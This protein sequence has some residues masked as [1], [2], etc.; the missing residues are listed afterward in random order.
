MLRNMKIRRK[1]IISFIIIGLFSIIVG[2]FGLAY[3]N[4]T[5][6]STVDIYEE[7]LIPSSYLF[8]VQ[9]NLI[10]IG[11]NYYLMLYEKD[12]AKAAKRVEEITAWTTADKELL[13]KFEAISITD[14]EKEIYTQLQ[15]DLTV[16][17][18]IRAEL[19]EFLLQN[20]FEEAVKLVPSFSEAREVVDQNI[21]E[22]VEVNQEG[23]KEAIGQSK[24]DFNTA[25]II[26]IAVAVAALL[27]ALGLGFIISGTISKPL[28][29]LVLAADRLAKGD[30]EVDINATSN[31]EVGILM[32]A[33]GKMVDNIKQQAENAR[34]IAAGDL[35]L[36]IKPGSDKDKLAFSMIEV[37]ET[38]K[39]LVAEAKAL[40]NAAVEGNLKNR[41]DVDKF[42]GGY[43]E[44]IN[45]FN[46]T[47]DAIVAP[48]NIALPY[49]EK[50]A[51]GDELEKLENNFEGEYSVL[52]ANLNLVGDALYT[53]LAESSS[54][55]EAAANGELTYRADV[56][57]L[58]G[59]YAQIVS[60]INDTL[61]SLINPLNIAASYIEKIGKGQIPDKITDTYKGDFNEIKN[62][63]N[64]CIDGLGGLVEGREI[65][66][67]MALND[68][69]NAVKGS[70]QGIYKDIADSVN[71]VNESIRNIIDILS[72]VS[73]GNLSNLESLKTIGRKCENDKLIPVGIA[74]IENIKNLIVETT[75]LSDAAI[76]GKLSSRGEAEKFNGEY[77]KI[78]EGI[79][80]T[81]DAVIEPVNEASAVL[82]EM[83]KGNLQIAMEGNYL[84]D[85]AAIKNA[86]NETL[87]N[88]R[89]YVSDI[90]R[91]LSEIS[92]GNLQ[93]AVTADYKGDFVEIKDS[94]NNIITS[95][96]QV[97]G[98]MNEA[99]DQVASGSRQVSDGSQALS[100][101][102]TEQASS[103]QQL[104][105]SIAEI[106]SQTKQN[107]TNA[108]QASELAVTARDNAEKGNDQMQGMLKSMLDIN[109]SSANISK[110][111][112]V[113]DDIAFQTNILALNAA[114]E[115]ARAGQHG[116][117]FAVVAEEVRNLAA[118]SANAAKE[119]AI[120]IEGSINKVQAGTKIANDT[121][122]ALVEIV[123]GVEKAAALVGGIAEASNEQ[124]SGIAQINKGIEQVAMVVQNNSATAEESAA[125]SEELSSQAEL[126][127]EMVSKFQI[128][129]SK[130]YLGGADPKMIEGT[131]T[132]KRVSN[133]K[134]QAMPQ[135]LLNDEDYDKY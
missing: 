11:S 10:L 58:K 113:I 26:M 74:L 112:K 98:D 38:L 122:T 9:K 77:A 29:Q 47:L 125:A 99:A 92:D 97:M 91:V 79:N 124:A 43:R 78:I 42:N 82:Q 50:I 51:N 109:D 37:V 134:V 6:D 32:R 60:G 54:L 36:D 96:S 107:A 100:Q 33:F 104:T 131:S 123:A 73:Q 88:L 27:L 15:E 55:T 35:E 20:N 68:F 70:Y 106:A 105:A 80:R 66:G 86:M 7:H 87:E 102:S 49:I 126:L 56:S 103:I 101:G 21:R 89:I 119:T 48:L 52:I 127:K 3:L 76:E 61:D 41:G 4:K 12:A 132:K 8:T 19:D 59:G 129:N 17:R 111:I 28:N 84:G 25:A 23:A 16:Y 116:K 46:S 110:I 117:G 90:S 44:I 53:L 57:K 71:L 14:K 94:L 118:R 85:H 95:L 115:A 63:I 121:A 64:A 5:N 62:S 65:L 83:A 128:N 135:I 39:A 30:D 93:L 1:L 40:T 67:E 75:M 18:G 45:G 24:E 133:N 31:D 120:L 34:R 81:L 69:S 13:L 2:S 108:N 114:V 72:N 22:L 130:K